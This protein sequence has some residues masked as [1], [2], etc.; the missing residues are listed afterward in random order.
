MGIFDIFTTD[1]QNK[2]AADQKTALAA[3]YTGAQ[4]LINGGKTDLTTNY[5]AALTPLQTTFDNAAT[6]TGQQGYQ[7][8]ADA[9]GAN[10]PEG[11]ARAKALFT[12]TPGY[13]EGINMTLDQNDRRAASRGMLASGNTDADT[14]KLATDYASQ[15]YGQYTAGLQPYTAV[16]GQMQGAASGIAG[17]NTGLGNALNANDLTL[18]SMFNNAAVGTG[19]A[20]ANADLASLTASGNIMNA[21]MAGLKLLAGA[22]GIPMPGGGGFSV[23]G[24]SGGPLNA[25]NWNSSLP[26]GSL[27]GL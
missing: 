5:A 20:N 18:G 12:Q 14:A 15:K 1:A 4:D 17:V 7:A 2:A 8:Y 16:P 21:S 11:L 22:G 13:S 3:G 23:G 27:T 26:A 6:G 10:G 25:A 19:N 9:T 24:G